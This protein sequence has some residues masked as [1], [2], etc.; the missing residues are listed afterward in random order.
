MTGSK[1]RNGG[2][3]AYVTIKHL[4]LELPEAENQGTGKTNRHHLSVE[5][6]KCQLHLGNR[7]KRA[8][9]GK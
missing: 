1:G 7:Q 2:T 3:T 9:N 4:Q 5:N 8:E 6:K